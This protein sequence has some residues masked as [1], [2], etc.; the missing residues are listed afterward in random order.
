MGTIGGQPIS[1]FSNHVPLGSS[2]GSVLLEGKHLAQ[3]V[4]LSTLDQVFIKDIYVFFSVQFSL[5]PD[6]SPSSSH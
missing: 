5:I 3:S 1:G 6:Q 4:V 2:Q